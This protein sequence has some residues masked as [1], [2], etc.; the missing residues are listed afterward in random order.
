MSG[1][2]TIFWSWQS[3][4]DE[5]VTRHL[6]RE[7]LVRALE[8][9]AG[10]AD[11]ED[12]LEI[13]HDTRGLPGSPDIVTSILAKI[14]AAAVFVGD[15]TPIA[16]SDS[17]KHVANPNV[18]I[19]LGYAK[20]ALSVDRV[21]TVWNTAFTSSRFEDLPFDLRGRRGPITYA[22]EAGASR[23]EL[24]AVRTVLVDEF[25]RRIGG[26]LDS[27]PAPTAS[28]PAWQPAAEND[29][30][31]WVEPGV[32]MRVNE[33]Y[34]SG[35]KVW[36][37]GG[38]WYVRVLPTSFDPAALDG[39]AHGPFIAGYGGFSWGRT[40]GGVLTYSGSVRSDS[41]PD[42]DGASMWF[43]TTGEIWIAQTG[44]ATEWRGRPCFY[45]DH[46]PEKWADL[47][48]SAL[49]RL[50]DNG[51]IGPFRA[52]LGVTGLAGLFW[53]EDNRF[54][55]EPPAALEPAVEVEFEVTGHDPK[56]LRTGLV[57]AWTNM[58]RV[59]GLP[60]P[61]DDLVEDAIS[62]ATR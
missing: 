11:I 18:L 31:L 42:L 59:F 57:A 60:P 39:G 8:R 61:R 48:F 32:E 27:L 17:G 45:G 35:V 20:K 3:D 52:R 43:R 28:G 62:K 49:K 56:S 37:Q 13:D 4:R 9:L 1:T 58:R 21:I 53:P 29:P 16:V 50:S 34:G 7:A 5:R 47:L 10:D 15:V 30:S 40:T 2:Q 19:E 51:G 25:V 41:G 23:K 14:D 33:D 46:V 22:L 36:G 55:G 54:G 6:I 38:R 12:R 44:V 24:A 26:C